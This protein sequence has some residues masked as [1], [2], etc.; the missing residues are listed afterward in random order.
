[1]Q[2]DRDGDGIADDRD[3]CLDVYDPG[4]TDEDHDGTGDACQCTAPAPGRCIAGGGAPPTDCLVE[5]NPS[6]PV[7]PNRKRTAVQAVL[8]C[9]EGD[10]ACDRDAAAD[11]QCTF[12]VSVCLANSDPRLGRCQAADIRDFEVVSPSPDRAR[13][14]TDRANSLAFEHALRTMGLAIHRGGRIVTALS[15]PAARD[16]CSPLIGLTVPAPAGARPSLRRFKVRATAADG[17]TDIDRLTL[18]CTR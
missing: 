9:R 3:V 4:Q 13:S 5:F 8:T 7:R 6:G 1:V 16:V 17:R 12:G 14:T 15:A 2:S 10:P 18:R 11:G